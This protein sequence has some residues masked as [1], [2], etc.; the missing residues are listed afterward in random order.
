[1]LRLG[2]FPTVRL[3]RLP[4]RHPALRDLCGGLFLDRCS[5]AGLC[6][7]SSLGLRI[8]NSTLHYFANFPGF[9]L[10]GQLPLLVGLH[11]SG[12]RSGLLGRFLG[13][14]DWTCTSRRCIRLQVGEACLQAKDSTK[15]QTRFNIE[16]FQGSAQSLFMQTW[17]IDIIILNLSKHMGFGC[18]C[19]HSTQRPSE[20]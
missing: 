8:S 14:A 16:V 1:M 3:C 19:L 5:R 18:C 12:P 4:L 6:V 17:Q 11:C 7:L 9:R 15:R 10:H 20:V 13:N 2:A